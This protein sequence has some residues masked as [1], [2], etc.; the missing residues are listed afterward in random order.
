[1]FV[2]KV[3]AKIM[4]KNVVHKICKPAMLPL[5]QQLGTIYIMVCVILLSFKILGGAVGGFIP[6]S[7]THGSNALH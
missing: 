1:M 3:N 5:I 2:E 4:T 6:A 7:H